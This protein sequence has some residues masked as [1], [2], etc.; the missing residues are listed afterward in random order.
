MGGPA[1]F[2]IWGVYRVIKPLRLHYTLKYWPADAKEALVAEPNIDDELPL[3]PW[4]TVEDKFAVFWGMNMAWGSSS[5]CPCPGA[6]PSD[7]MWHIL[8]LRGSQT[9]K[10]AVFKTLI[11][12][13]RGDTPWPDNS[14]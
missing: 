8:L 5:A 11:G 2:T 13:E 6:L 4:Q 14:P 1:R 7:G 10:R 9:T 3:G 12:L